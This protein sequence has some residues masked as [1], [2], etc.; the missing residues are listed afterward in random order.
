M[1]DFAYT[2]ST[3]FL[4]NEMGRPSPAST[5]VLWLDP[6]TNAPLGSPAFPL[7]LLYETTTDFNTIE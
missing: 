5:A 1:Q 4:G 7:S 2:V 6:D 3:F